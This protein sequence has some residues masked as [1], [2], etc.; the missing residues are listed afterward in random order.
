[1]TNFCLDFR[2]RC[3]ISSAIDLLMRPAGIVC[4]WTKF[5]FQDSSYIVSKFLNPR[6]SRQKK[7]NPF[8]VNFSELRNKLVEAFTTNGVEDSV[9]FHCLKSFFLFWMLR[10][11]LLH[12]QCPRRCS[13]VQNVPITVLFFPNQG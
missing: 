12:F 9:S 10:N 5:Q 1:M 3:Q 8:K 2:I 7:V 6:V 4:K 13:D 11:T